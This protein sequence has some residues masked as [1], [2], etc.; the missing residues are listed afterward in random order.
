MKELMAVLVVLATGA[1]LSRL[2]RRGSEYGELLQRTVD[3]FRLGDGQ[4]GEELFEQLNTQL[5]GYRDRL[6]AAERLMG[7]RAWEHALLLVELALQTR[8]EDSRL[9]RLKARLHARLLR[10]DGPDLLG[11]WVELHP[12]DSE[13]RL[14][15]CE[16]LLRM[17]RLEEA[18]ES[19]RPW[20]WMFDED[21]HAHSLLGRVY[22]DA[23]EFEL[24]YKLL[25]RAQEL[26]DKMRRSVITVC[27]GGWETGYDFRFAVEAQWEEER[28]WLLLEQIEEGIAQSQVAVLAQ[29]PVCCDELVE[30]PESVA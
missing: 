10:G 4:E 21:I 3:A 23:G 22:F 7:A 14:E 9:T 11:Q 19:L 1:S 5:Q 13:T 12:R 15:L 16:L 18:A 2:S 20:M 26:R 17:S 8:P 6:R 29:E 30:V 25:F 27:E 24:A 28:D